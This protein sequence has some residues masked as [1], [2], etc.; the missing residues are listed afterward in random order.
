MQDHLGDYCV[1]RRDVVRIRTD[2]DKYQAMVIRDE[3]ISL[4]K[5][6]VSCCVYK[7]A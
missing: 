3:H 6:Q 1:H 7:V 2:L 4:V 5:L